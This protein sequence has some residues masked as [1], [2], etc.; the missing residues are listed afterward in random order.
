MNGEKTLREVCQIL[1]IS[2]RTIQGYQNKGLIHPDGR[3]KYGHLLF[4]DF[5]MKKIALFRFY[6][7]MGFTLDEINEL[8]DANMDVVIEKMKE[9]LLL[10]ENQQKELITIHHKAIQVIQTIQERKDI[11]DVYEILKGDQL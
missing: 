9:R 2:R 8:A 1:N 10:L 4:N 3:N 11:D 7:R 5:T 6:Q